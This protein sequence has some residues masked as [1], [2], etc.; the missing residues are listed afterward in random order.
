MDRGLIV[1][2]NDNDMSIA[3]PVGA[4]SAYLSRLA[5]GPHLSYGARYRQ[6][7]SPQHLPKSIDRTITPRRGARAGL[8]D[9]RHAV[10]GTRLLLCRPDRRAQSRRISCRCCAT[11]ATARTAPILV[12]VVTQKGK[13]YAPAEA[14]ADK[15]HGVS[16]FDVVTG[17][18]VKPK[19]NAPAYTQVFA[20]SLIKAARRTTTHRRHHGRDAVRHRPRSLR[21][22]VPRPHLRRRHRRAARGDVRGRAGHRRLQAVLRHLLHL[23]AARL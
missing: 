21:Q 9:R 16:M 23:P 15:Y 5:L 12:H 1:I 13:G 2:L 11:C 3:P 8:P 7:A 18:Q 4:M 22:G 20:E 6:A 19:A 17:A 10:R 14:S